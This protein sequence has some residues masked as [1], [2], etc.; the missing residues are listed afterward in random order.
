M[1]APQDASTA[2]DD[3]ALRPLDVDGVG[4]V[5]L[6]TAVWTVLAVVLCTQ[7]SSLDAEGRGW[8]LGVCVAGAVLGLI[9]LPY[10]VARRRAYRASSVSSSVSS[11]AS[12]TGAASDAP[13][14]G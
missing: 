12:S 7:R 9:G 14:S 4:A 1:P 10:V 8:W 6:G 11:S 13:S 2:A 3:P 5:A